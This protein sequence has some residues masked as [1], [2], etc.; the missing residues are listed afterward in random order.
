MCGSKR[1]I[2]AWAHSVFISRINSSREIEERK[3]NI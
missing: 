1:N 2:V 3:M